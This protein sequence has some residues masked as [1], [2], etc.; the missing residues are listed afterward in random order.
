MSFLTLFAKIKSSRIFPNLQHMFLLCLK[1]SSLCQGML[2]DWLLPTV[3]IV[4]S[5]VLFLVVLPSGARQ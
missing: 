1:L 2:A 5:C 3:L 4:F